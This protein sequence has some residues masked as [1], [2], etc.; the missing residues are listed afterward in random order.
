MSPDQVAPSL[1]AMVERRRAASDALREQRA[2][3]ANAYAEAKKSGTTPSG[4]VTAATAREWFAKK[5]GAR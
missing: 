4:E 1:A 2:A 5:A 3:G